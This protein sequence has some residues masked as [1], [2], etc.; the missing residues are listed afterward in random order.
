MLNV[1]HKNISR[2]SS[3][4]NHSKTKMGVVVLPCF[5][6]TRYLLSSFPKGHYYYILANC[7]QIVTNRS[8]HPNEWMV[9]VVE[10]NST[11]SNN[12]VDAQF[13]SWRASY[14]DCLPLL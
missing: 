12:G 10:I 4:I 2:F 7:N 5:T 11:I 3:N 8:L 1:L 14:I 13:T 6:A 9:V